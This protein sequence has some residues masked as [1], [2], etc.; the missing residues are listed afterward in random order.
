MVYV[1]VSH[2]LEYLLQN[3]RLSGIQR[4]T[5]NCVLG[6]QNVLGDENVRIVAF[7]RNLKQLCVG[8]ASIISDLANSKM[9]TALVINGAALPEVGMH[10]CTPAQFTKGDQL[11][12]TEWFWNSSVGNAFRELRKTTK[13]EVFRFIHDVLPLAIPEYFYKR[14]VKEFKINVE[15][16]LSYAD[17]VLTNSD[18]SKSDL[19]RLCGNVLDPNTPIHVLKLPHEFSGVANRSEPTSVQ[20]SEPYALM[21]GTL[22]ERK[23]TLAVVQAWRR[24][25]REHGAKLP[26]LLLVGKFSWFDW[27]TLKLMI[28]LQIDRLTGAP[29][30]RI[31]NC[32]DTDLSRLYRN[33]LFSIYVSKYEG[34]GLPIGEC[35]W[36]GRPVLAGMATSLPEV[37]G[38]LVDYVDVE[39]KNSLDVALE[40][41]IFNSQ[42]LE[43]RA[44][45][46][47]EAKLRTIQ[48]FINS[49][50]KELT[51][52]RS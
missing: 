10:V 42:H 3:R 5:L 47:S 41:L 48:D 35:L 27:T 21:V 13:V 45:R 31:K 2:L 51:E 7:D 26:K 24:L 43:H 23:N 18:Y 12:L 30:I 29:I 46:I 8:S 32:N 40:S 34:W 9:N 17:V 25:W 4:V 39:E 44:K 37:G 52:T 15:D 36:F 22:E 49:L 6:L 19:R 33:C 11:L 20:F 28:G 50:A 14:L 38:D 16:A 1:D